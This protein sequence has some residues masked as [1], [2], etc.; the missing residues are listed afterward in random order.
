[1]AGLFRDDMSST[2]DQTAWVA[3]T[4]NRTGRSLA[5]SSR[6]SPTCPMSDT[7]LAPDVLATAADLD[8]LDAFGTSI[9]FG[10]IFEAQKTLVVFIREY[11]APR[12]EA[13]AFSLCSQATFTAACV[14]LVSPLTC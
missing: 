6:P 1:M 13:D 9:K 7:A 12:L 5:K 2:A 11:S 3:V 4:A 10:S 14:G 8:V